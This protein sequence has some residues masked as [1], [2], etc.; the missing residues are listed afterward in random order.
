MALMKEAG[1][2]SYGLLGAGI[3]F[4]FY[5]CDGSHTFSVTL[6]KEGA[7]H[8]RPK[9]DRVF[10]VTNEGD[11]READVILRLIEQMVRVR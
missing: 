9:G 1:G 11:V 3:K 7:L 4:A 2:G 10:T 8:D 6:D 5:H